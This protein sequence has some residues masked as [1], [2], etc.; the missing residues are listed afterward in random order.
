MTVLRLKRNRLDDK[1]TSQDNVIAANKADADSKNTVTNDRVTEEVGRLDTKNEE[2]DSALTATRT[3]IF[4]HINI[5]NNSMTTQFVQM[6]G[7]QAIVDSA[8]DDKIQANS[9]RLDSLGYRVNENEKMLS[10]GIA[11]SVAL[12]QMPTP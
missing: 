9:D 6:Q 2:Q 11:S 5:T 12:A 7:N 1:N 8:Q 3:E 4:N 10:A